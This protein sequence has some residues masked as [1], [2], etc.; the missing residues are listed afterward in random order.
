MKNSQE[1]AETIKSE[2]NKKNIKLGVMCSD[3]DISNN[4]FH[5]MKKSM[6][7]IETLAKIAEY[8]N[9]SLDDLLGIKNK[10]APETKRNAITNKINSLTDSQLDRLLGYLE[11]LVASE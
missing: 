8:L 3:L 9:C 11:A 1:I 2:A 4:T 6:P 5:N 7:S 10:C